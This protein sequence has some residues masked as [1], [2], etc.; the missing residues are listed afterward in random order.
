MEGWREAFTAGEWRVY[1]ASETLTEADLA[2][3]ANT[4][5]GRPAGSDA[6]VQA[7]ETALGRRLR[8]G[9]GG[10]PRAGS[11]AA[12][13]VEPAQSLLFGDG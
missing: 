5:S 12:A 1:L 7:A 6:F 3:R 10:R 2:L 4:Y 11:S 9:K 8:A 13:G